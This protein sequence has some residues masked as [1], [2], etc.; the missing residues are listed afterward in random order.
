VS[1]GD[2]PRRPPLLLVV[3][4]LA[5]GGAEREVVQLARGLAGR[6]WPVEVVSLLAG[7]ALEGE[8]VASGVPLHGLGMRRGRPS[9][10]AFARYLA[11]LRHLRPAIVHSFMVHANLLARLA[12]PFA[13][14]HRLVNTIQNSWEGARWREWAYRLTDRRADLVSQVSAAGAERYR[15][16]RLV[17][18]QRLV[19]VPNSVDLARFR[20]DPAAR[21]AVR[22]EL[23]APGGVPVLLSMARLEP[24]K[25]HDN[26]LR[27]LAELVRRGV[28][29]A[30]WLAGD[31]AERGRLERL[32]A[33]LQLGDHLHFLGERADPERLLAAADLLVLSSRW[34][35]MPLVLLE[36][37]ACGL[38]VVA[39]AVGGVEELIG[40]RPAGSAPDT[41]PAAPRGPA[42]ATPAAGEL[43]PPADPAALAAAL[44]RLLADP[45]TSRARAHHLA[46][47]VR[48][49][50]ALDAHLDLWEQHYER[51]LR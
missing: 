33:E 17:S 36:A 40:P 30:A 32:A 42:E 19:V 46:Q 48:S 34:E 13:V 5:R 4:G 35:G 2:R 45:E 29:F 8:L 7:G 37:G 3:T 27:S 20:P 38:P 43:V 51:L 22:R 16:L 9:L 18:P 49:E 25:D 28:G 21:E 44:A 24:Q 50:Y 1:L 39:T 11:L 41:P 26:L 14:P 15:R 47:R 31:G 23:R 12:R 10:L 6:G